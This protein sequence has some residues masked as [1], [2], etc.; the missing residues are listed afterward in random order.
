MTI[1]S[2]SDRTCGI[3]EYCVFWP[4]DPSYAGICLLADSVNVNKRNLFFGGISSQNLCRYSSFAENSR[5]GTRF[6]REEIAEIVNSAPE[7][8]LGKVTAADIIPRC[9]LILKNS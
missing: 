5:N 3:C 8:L 9:G 2:N 1:K 6:T 7:T 4:E